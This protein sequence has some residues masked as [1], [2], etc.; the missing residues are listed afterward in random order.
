LF[1]ETGESKILSSNQKKRAT[2]R[3]KKQAEQVEKRTKAKEARIQLQLEKK[4]EKGTYYVI[5]VHSII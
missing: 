5:L 2:K 3:L 1:T 4:A